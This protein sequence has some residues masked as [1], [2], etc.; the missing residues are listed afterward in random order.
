MEKQ[1][2]WC[3]S[4]TRGLSQRDKPKKVINQLGLQIQMYFYED[5]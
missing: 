2:D 5:Q 4:K 1:K 3:D